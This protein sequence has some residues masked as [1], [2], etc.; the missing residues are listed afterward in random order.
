MPTAQRGSNFHE[1]VDIMERLLAPDGCP[2][3]REQTLQSLEPFLIEEAYEV[4]EAIDLDSGLD[5]ARE[6][7]EELGDLLFQIVFQSALRAR[8]G[9]FGID[10]VVRAIAT[11][12]IRRHP[13]VFGDAKVKDANEVLANWGKLK[14]IE[15]KEKGIARRALEG[16]PVNLPALLRAQRLGE[17][18]AAVGFDWPDVA[19]VR[20]K[21]DEELREIDEAVKGGDPA[22][23]EHE[24][25]DLLLAVS[26]LSAKLGVAPEDALRSALRRFQGRFE[27]M[28]DRV[29]ARGV[30][31]G[32]TPL[33]ELDRIWNEVK[34]VEPALPK[35]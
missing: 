19:G 34:K 28:E 21:V 10:D 18:A 2:W 14:E 4:L 11:K 20:E 5:G 1:L 33:E 15:H 12:M 29:I 8:E 3:D 27:A 6:H 13:H 23:I 32:D 25:G 26:R 30:K 9:K 16:V 7:C 17:K 24:L 22:Q 35:K 31:V